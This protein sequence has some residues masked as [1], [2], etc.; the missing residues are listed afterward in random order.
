MKKIYLLFLIFLPLK[1]VFAQ[2]TMMIGNTEVQVDTVYTGLDVP[3]EIQYGPDGNLWFTERKGLVSKL[4]PVTKI[5]TIVL[6]IVDE[7]YQEYEAGLLGMAL[8]PDFMNTP[9]IFIVYTYGTSP[10]VFEKLVK[11]TYNG[12]ALAN[13]VIVLDNINGFTTHNGSRIIFLPDNKI[14]MTTGDAQDQPAAQDLNSLNGKILRLNMDGSIP[15]DNPSPTS[16]VYTYGHRNIQGLHLA[17]NDRVYISEHGATTDDEFQ[18]LA[19]NRN[20]GWPDVE[21]YCDLPGEETFCTANDVEEPLMA[22]TPTIAPSDLIYYDNDAF[23]EFDD[24]ILMT[25]L[26]D[27]KVRAISLNIP[28][29]A[30]TDEDDYFTQM[31]GRLRDIAMGPQ[32]ELYLATN[33]AEWINVDPNT[34]SIIRIT[35][36]TDASVNEL[37]KESGFVMHPNPASDFLTIDLKSMPGGEL[38]IRDLQGKLLMQ[39]KIPAGQVKL[40]IS[41]LNRGLYFVLLNGICRTLTVN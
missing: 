13:P 17:P 36:P 5:R 10:N 38:T 25:V 11:Y 27:K 18:L 4:D 24:K 28:G 14:L 39:Q 3:W 16:Y 31:F 41:A 12:T 30:V 33:G 20:Y 7:V 15:A 2:S 37:G 19:P 21:G 40:D 22:W 32:K 1:S 23:P 8:H 9:E 26:K 29:N 34:H 6:D 35:P